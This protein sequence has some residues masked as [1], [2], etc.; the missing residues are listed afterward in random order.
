MA[1]DACRQLAGIAQPSLGVLPHH[2]EHAEPNGLA[3]GLCRHQGL[4]DETTEHVDDIAEHR[5]RGGGIE[6]E[7]AR[8]HGQ[9]TEHDALVVLQKV[10]TPVERGGQGL[11]AVGMAVPTMGQDGECIAQ[12]GG[13]LCDREMGDAHSGQLQGERDTVETATDLGDRGRRRGIE[14]EA[15]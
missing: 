5:H 6:V 10:V 11:L 15:R 8:K 1:F 2:L 9:T 12:A 7:A 4:V 13:E 3:R 14:H